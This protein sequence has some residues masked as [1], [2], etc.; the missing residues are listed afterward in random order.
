MA[1]R[2]S[3]PRAV[4]ADEVAAAAARIAAYVRRT[5][6]IEVDGAVFGLDCRLALK[7]EHL[8]LS[9]SFKARGA[10]NRLLRLGEDASGAPVV[11]ASGGNHGAAVAAAAR[12]LGRRAEIFLPRISSPAKRALIERFGATLHVVGDEFSEALAA[13]QARAADL[14]AEVIHAY[15]HPDTIAGQGTVALEMLEE[16]GRLDAALVAAGGGGLI[17]GIAAAVDGRAQILSVETERTA[18]LQSAA[19]AG[20]PVDVKVG[21]LA[22]DALG[23]RR[24]GDH[25]WATIA[26]RVSSYCLVTDA[27]LRRAQ[28]ALWTELRLALEP[29][30]AAPLAAL[31]SG[32]W[33]PEPGARVGLVLCGGNVD[34]ATIG[35]DM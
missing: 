1:S 25:V 26:R 5:P 10:F 9:G 12:R 8:Q 31:M 23:A 22:A 29:S 35:V 19:V 30:A 17:A 28:A 24:A 11:A 13:A 3:A 18:T 34:L 7:L 6:S 16:A 15:D 32:V 2:N 27:A 20:R 4:A 14:G 33:A 21:G